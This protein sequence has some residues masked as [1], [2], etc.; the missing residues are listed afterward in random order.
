MA[1]IASQIENRNN[2]T[3]GRKIPSIDFLA[4]FPFAVVFS[5]L[6]IIG[7]LYLFYI[8]GEAKYGVDFTGGYE[9]LVSAKQN[10]SADAIRS[11][12]SSNGYESAIVQSFEG[13]GS[14]YL[15]R[16]EGDEKQ[17]EIL[18]TKIK[19]IV[20]SSF[21]AESNIL[22]QDF[23]GPSVGQELR[24]KALLAVFVALGAMLVFIS[25]RFEF[26]FALGAVVALFHDVIISTGI[27]LLSGQTFSMGAV[28]AAL[29]IV[30]YS[31]NDTI[32]IFDR[33]REEVFHSQS[34]ESLVSIMN[35]CINL[36][37]SRTLITHILT[38]FS[39][40]GLYFFGGGAISDL[41]LYLLAGIV[42]GSY[43]TIYIA[44]PVVL[45]WHR[46]SG[47]KI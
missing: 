36:M 13:N 7:S 46:L 32:V 38:L 23:V 43:S 3:N 37:L 9:F 39:A 11:A 27:Y 25:V 45:L 17:S 22:R 4:V 24:G 21:G 20:Q 26:A 42:C 14:E 6:L 35:R 2:T 16:L 40:A 44:C 1:A 33:I 28:A 5:L 19:Q 30:G 31:V 34:K 41:S 8:G 29:T 18:N 15:I 12:L 10:G 47:G